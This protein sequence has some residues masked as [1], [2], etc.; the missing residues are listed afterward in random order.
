V[1]K[2]LNLVF[3][4]EFAMMLLAKQKKVR[5]QRRQ[6]VASLLSLFCSNCDV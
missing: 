1:A 4:F 2:H 6:V 3:G 5:G